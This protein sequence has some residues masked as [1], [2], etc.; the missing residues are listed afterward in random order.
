MVMIPRKPKEGDK[1]AAQVADKVTTPA[2]AAQQ[3]PGPAAAAPVEEAAPAAGAVAVQGQ[4][5]VSTHLMGKPRKVIEERYKDAFKVDWNTLHRVQAVQGSF[6]DVENN[7]KEI[8]K[9]ITLELLSFQ[10]NWQ[11]SPGTDVESDAQYVRYSDDGVTTTQGENCAEYLAAMKE[12]GYEA[13]KMAKR[14]TLAGIIVQADD[15]AVVNQMVQIDLPPTSK[16]MF[17]RY[18]LQASLDVARGVRQDDEA[19]GTMKMTARVQSKGK[20]SW[21]V[22]EFSTA[23]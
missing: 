22:V 12:A 21:T 2:A 10:D 7:K 4:R 1:P 15:P 13:V 8:G 9:S 16:T 5:A 14:C 17:D 6:V 23:S 19:L 18:Q 11:I 3:T 20:F